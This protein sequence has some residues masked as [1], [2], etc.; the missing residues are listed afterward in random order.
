[1]P[2]AVRE[3]PCAGRGPLLYPE[4]FAHALA[5]LDVDAAAL[6]ELAARRLARGEELDAPEPLYLRRPDAVPAAATPVGA[7]AGGR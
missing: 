2:A 4:Q 1:M 3:L 5:P 7:P 6:A